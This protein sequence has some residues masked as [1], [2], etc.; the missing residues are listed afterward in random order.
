MDFSFIIFLLFIPFS[1]PKFIQIHDITN[2]PGALTLSAGEGRILEGYNRLLHTVDL[3]ELGVT[4]GI[5]E[6]LVLKI[7][8]STGDFSKLID[9]K[10]KEISN[11][12]KALL[13]NTSRNKRSIETLGS[14]IKFITGNLDA[15]DLRQ[16]NSNINAIKISDM[17]LINESIH[18]KY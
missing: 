12:Y 13:P 11:T 5:L 10:L 7:N 6:S 18:G 3:N 9:H 1:Y 16:I 2:N 17:F 8:S 14:A 4:I 15:Q